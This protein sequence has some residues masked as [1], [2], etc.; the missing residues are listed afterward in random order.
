M[1]IDKSKNSENL[2][3]FSEN[4]E[5]GELASWS[6]DNEPTDADIQDGEV[7]F[8]SLPEATQK[9]SKRFSSK[10]SVSK[11]NNTEDNEVAELDHPEDLMLRAEIEAELSS[12]PTAEEPAMDQ[13]A[14][15]QRKEWSDEP[16]DNLNDIII[17][18]T[19][20]SIDSDFE[21]DMLLV[22]AHNELDEELSVKQEDD[23][24]EAEF[25]DAA[26]DD[27]TPQLVLE[28]QSMEDLQESDEEVNPSDLAEKAVELG[29]E[30][31]V[32][33]IIFASP[34]PLKIGE[35]LEILGEEATSKEISDAVSSIISFYKGRSGGFSLEAVRG[36]YQFQTSV[37]ASQYMQRM[38][39]SRPR[40]ISRAA[41]ETLA[42]IAYRQPVTR[43]D[44][45]FIRGVDAGSIVKNLLDRGLIKAVGRKEDAGRP[46]LFGTTDEFLQIYSLQS[47]NDLPPLESFQ[48]SNDLVNAGMDLIDEKDKPVH[49]GDFVGNHDEQ[50]AEMSDDVE[51]THSIEITD[52]NHH[53]GE[54]VEDKDQLS[55]A[56]QFDLVE[57]SDMTAEEDG[58]LPAEAAQPD[59]LD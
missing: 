42:I 45:E 51:N 54:N 20:M 38:F 29:L 21:A 9:G 10:T 59:L 4:A 41:Q 13:D 46:I 34:R 11:S 14:P 33:A 22:D 31:K 47:L 40:P 27:N 43:A 55:G 30:A 3:K 39:S 6:V 32:E 50:K 12:E 15:K 25:V 35:I 18:E 49:E 44:I 48:P 2:E 52:G 28:T 1:T 57:I 58:P 19:D 24:F 37:G 8:F 56:S 16:D 36:G 23:D 7:E 5:H 26:P 53:N 17:S